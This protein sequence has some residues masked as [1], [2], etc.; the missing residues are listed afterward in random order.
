M[1]L[2]RKTKPSFFGTLARSAAIV[3]GLWIA[4][5]VL[6]TKAAAEE[7]TILGARAIGMGGAG[8][9]LSRGSLSNHWNPAGL[10]PPGSI[11]PL[12]FFDYR[13]PG[14]VMATVTND[15]I[16]EIDD[17]V[18]LVDRLDFNDIEN[19]LANGNSLA[20]S[21]IG[22]LLRVAEQL[23]E[24]GKSGSGLIVDAAAGI[25]I[26]LWRF[27]V[28]ALGTFHGGGFTKLDLE[29]LALGSSGIGAV[30]PGLGGTPATA[31]GVAFSDQLV[32]T[33]LVTRAQ[34]DEIAFF[35]E[36]AEVNINDAGFRSLIVDVL[37]ATDANVGGPLSNLLTNN[38]SGVDFR[39]LTTQEVGLGYAQPL[40][41]LFPL[42]PASWV[43]VGAT[44]KVIRG[45]TYFNGFSLNDL[46]DFDDLLSEITDNEDESTSFN[47]GV[48]VGVLVQPLDWISVGVVAKNLNRPEFDF[49]GPG[50]YKLDPQI[51]A[52][53]GLVDI[54]DGVTLAADIDVT[55]NQ[56]DSLPGRTS[57]MVGAGI[58]Y[59]VGDWNVLFLRGGVSQNLADF[60]EGVGIHAGFSVRALGVSIDAAA[61]VSPEFTSLESSDDSDE[62]PERGGLGLELSVFVPID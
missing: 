29:T 58:E 22:D 5:V 16:Q 42:P 57:Q 11:S 45:T 18:E 62:V 60:N 23:P 39:A 25:D 31:A 10:A 47:V 41:E 27:G 24:L 15:V 51:R 37:E 36:A 54:L 52:G 17:V 19:R 21:Q 30:V 43:S 59:D 6:A 28:S 50:D 20:P 2:Q 33:G 61:M 4:T 35:S 26:R 53:I 13:V 3:L 56:S 7:F 8:V 49:E 9:A 38:G 1:S 12:R 32:A 34:A 55:R 46:Q 44:V 40:G 48:D 14:A